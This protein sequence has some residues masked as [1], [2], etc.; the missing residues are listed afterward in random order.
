MTFKAVLQ[1][2]TNVPVDKQKITINKKMV[3]D[4]DDLSTM[5]L[6]DGMTIMLLGTA[7]QMELKAPEK[8]IKFIEDMTPE[9]KAAALQ[10]KAAIVIPAGLVNL[11]N[12]CYMASTV[13][14][15]SRVKELK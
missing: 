13:Q 4:G 5:G 8:P 2:M 6:K 9:E 12:T 15:L 1:S 7:S 10:E 14:C 11:G 3:K